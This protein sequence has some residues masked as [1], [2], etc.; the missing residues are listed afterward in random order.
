MDKAVKIIGVMLALSFLGIT[1]AWAEMRPGAVTFTPFVGGY[2]F[3]GNQEIEDDP[4][5]GVGLGVD[6]TE[7]F[8]VEAIFNYIDT[9]D[10]ILGNDIDTYVYHLDGLFYFWP[11]KKLA[12]Y[13]AAGVG[14]IT[15]NPA[16]AK[17]D[18]DLQVN[19]GL[20][21][22]YFM[23]ENLAIRGDVRHLISFDDTFNN[24]AY[25]LGLTYHFG[26]QQVRE[27]AAGPRDS[28]GD[29]VPDD[30]DACPGTPPGTPVDEKGCPKDSD[31]DG[32]YD[33]LDECP[34]TPAGVRVDER[35]C[36]LQKEVCVYLDVYFDFDRAEIKP[37][38]H[39]DLK[40]IADFMKANPDQKATIKGHAD[41]IGTEEYNQKLS[42]RRAANIKR[43]LVE[44]FDINADRIDTVGLGEKR[45][46]ATNETAYGR[47]LNRRANEV[48][49]TFEIMFK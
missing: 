12:P 14:A 5:L 13:L 35:G 19:Y 36:P 26:G 29:G 22:K 4:L 28:D 49:C 23:T 39:D 33:Y 32:I 41:Y 40:K 18:T 34:D 46:V 24:L 17:S 45:P 2:M 20:G 3:E 1:G 43:Y 37:R 11:N 42:E 31:G 47:Q 30:Q 8:G 38:H 15:F 16:E 9:E 21:L 10:E 27:V 48:I 6:L 7:H 44:N 25:A